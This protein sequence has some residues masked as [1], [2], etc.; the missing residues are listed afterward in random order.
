MREREREKERETERQRETERLKE[1][2]RN[3]IRKTETGR[4]QII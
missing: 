1:C 3:E 4:I 2:I